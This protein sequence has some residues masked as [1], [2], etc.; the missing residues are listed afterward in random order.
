MN[1]TLLGA[2]VALALGAAVAYGASDFLGG[3]ASRGESVWAVAVTS[4]ATAAALAVPFALA[5]YVSPRAP[6]VAWAV[7][8]GIG[9]GAGNVL[10]YHGLATGRMMVVAP[11]AAVTSTTV[12]VVVD[13][14]G[15][16]HLSALTVLGVAAALAAVWLSSGGPDGER[17][18]RADVMVGLLA[19]AGFGAQFSALGQVPGDA[20]LTPVAI[21]Q[22]VSVG[23]IVA[24]ALC[25]RVRWLPRRRPV[26]AMAA[27]A[28]AGTATLLFQLSAQAGALTVAAVLTSLYPAVTVALAA[29]VLRERTTRVQVAGMTLALVAVVLVR[30][31]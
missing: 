15:G 6:D 13:L 27:G 2:A 4:Q 29:V 1:E 14:L 7:V 18:G 28:L 23:C 5:T 25:L 10:M 22:V 19:G 8:A 24:T 30:S 17:A 12:P 21:S 9:A 3:M 11:V 16:R 20:G 31:G 26:T